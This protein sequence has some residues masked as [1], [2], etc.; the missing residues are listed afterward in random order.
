MEPSKSI[1]LDEQHHGEY[2]VEVLACGKTEWSRNSLYFDTEEKAKQ[3]GFELC[4]RWLAMED[5]RVC[6]IP[7]TD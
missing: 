2:V 3:Y 7:S 6:Q 5:W 4:L 1:P